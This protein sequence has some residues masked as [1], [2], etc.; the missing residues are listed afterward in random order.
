MKY[1][2]E[3]RFFSSC[4]RCKKDTSVIDTFDKADS[5]LSTDVLNLSLDDT[6]P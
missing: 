4:I 2:L 5:E 3:K 6:N 1:H